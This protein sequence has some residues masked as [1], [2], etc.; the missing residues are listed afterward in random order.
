AVCGPGVGA[1][2]I[3]CDRPRPRQH[4]ADPGDRGERPAAGA[5]RAG[6]TGHGAVD[7][8]AR[9][10][11]TGPPNPAAPAVRGPPHPRPRPRYAMTGRYNDS[12]W[13]GNASRHVPDPDAQP[14]ARSGP[15]C[16]RRSLPAP[17]VGPWR[18]RR[19]WTSVMA[20]G[21]VAM[22]MTSAGRLSTSVLAECVRLATAAPSVHNSQPW[23]FRIRHGAVDVFVD[24]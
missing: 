14:A 22:F 2:S 4:A 13:W 6:Q 11:R 10:R 7:T 16:G 5:A 3:G 24:R 18:S 15:R 23:R 8:P 21:G 17:A 19:R 12:D 20:S 9:L 1:G